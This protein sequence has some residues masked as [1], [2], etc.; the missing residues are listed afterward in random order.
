MKY[1]TLGRTGLLVSEIG[2]G[3]EGFV[4]KPYEF[5]KQ[6]V[7]R[8]EEA[9]INCIDLY[10]PHPDRTLEDLEASLAY[11]TASEEEKDYA[12][13]FAA[14]PK[15]SWQG[16]CM[17]CGHCAPC[18]MG[19]SVAD[20]TK[21]LN[22]SRAQGSV[23]ETVREHYALLPHTASECLSCGQ[24]EERCPFGVP[25]VENMRQAAELFGR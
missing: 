1:R 3:C 21:F 19:I 23:P 5:V 12:A 24:C 22:L 16:H 17:Y 4:E 14:L 13:A 20:V 18:P 11:E 8:M 10:A 6:F 9:G 15:I 25:V 7:D 2:M